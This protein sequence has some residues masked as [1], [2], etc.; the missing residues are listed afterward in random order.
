MRCYIKTMTIRL[1][2][3]W[4]YDMNDSFLWER[5]DF[6]SIKK[7]VIDKIEDNTGK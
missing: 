2:L 5:T 1:C 6:K 3:Q 7:D 4:H